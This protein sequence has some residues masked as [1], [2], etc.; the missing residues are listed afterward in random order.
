MTDQAPRRRV[1]RR[2]LS[3]AVVAV[4]VVVIVT[5]GLLAIR[6]WVGSTDQQTV[7]YAPATGAVPSP[8]RGFYDAIDDLL[9]TQDFSQSRADGITLI[10]AYVRLDDF[11]SGPISATAL[12]TLQDGFDALRTQGMKVVLRFAYNAG[13]YPDSQPDAPQS[14]ILAQ[15][16]QLTPILAKND[17]VIAAVEAGFIGAWGEWHSSTNGLDK[18]PAAK[19][20]VLAAVLAAVPANRDV[21]VR[22]PADIRALEGPT[23]PDIT[24]ANAAA[25]SRIGNHQDCFL[26]GD[27][28]DGGTWSRDGSSVAKDKAMIAA[29][30][31]YAMVGGETCNSTPPASSNCTNA[32]AQLSQ[33]EFTY[34]NRDYEPNMLARFKAQGCYETIAERLGYRIQL[35]DATFPRSLDRGATSFDYSF[36]IDNVGFASPVNARPAYLVVRGAG[37]TEQ[38]A[39]SADVRTW[40]PGKT[41]VSGTVTLPSTLKPGRYT[42]ALWLPDAA[43]DLQ[44]QPAYSIRLA[45]LKVWNATTG[46]NTFGSFTVPKS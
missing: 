22:Y 26:F 35:T 20:S 4:I 10:H 24:S 16:V 9:T 29:I 44:A 40:D 25:R 32:L 14:V 7:G 38:L 34:L 39:V 28:T 37:V 12:A 8:E 43:K 18:D 33:M 6:A 23:P 27:A 5:V 45:S 17:D 31:R 30:G 1:P 15:L 11:R 41:I 13:P 21:L 3:I 42:L 2:L 46:E 36:T 19:K